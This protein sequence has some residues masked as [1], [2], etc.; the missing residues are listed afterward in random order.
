MN[1]LAI[2][3]GSKPIFLASIGRE[4]PIILAIITVTTSVKHTTNATLVVTLSI[5]SSLAKFA[6]ASVSPART[7]TLISFHMT[8]NVSLYSISFNER[9]R[10]IVTDD[11]PPAFPPVSISIG[12]NEVKTT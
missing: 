9:P 2:T 10:I 3:A 6:I 7:A 4:H 5:R 11:C 12:M 1:G 8:F